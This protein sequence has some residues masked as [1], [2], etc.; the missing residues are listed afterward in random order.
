[1]SAEESSDD[2]PEA[3]IGWGSGRQAARAA[4]GVRRPRRAAASWQRAA[5]T[6]DLRADE[7]F[8][9]DLL[10]QLPASSSPSAA[11]AAPS[12]AAH[13][14]RRAAARD[15][16]RRPPPAGLPQVVRTEHNVDVAVLP[17]SPSLPL[18]H[19]AVKQGLDVFLRE[20]L[21][22]RRLRRASGAAIAS[23]KPSRGRFG[24]SAEFASA[25]PPAAPLQ[26]KRKAR[27]PP[28]PPPASSLEKMAARIMQRKAARA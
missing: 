14:K 5:V 4:C 9:A 7:R 10:A 13:P 3:I 8:P 12:A 1:M 11:A 22:G 17:S 18:P 6:A 24:A 2:E 20:A 26:R 23:L 19:A 15:A 21:Y 16:P 25:A 28:P 27:A